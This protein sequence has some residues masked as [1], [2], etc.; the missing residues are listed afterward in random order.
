MANT[1]STNVSYVALPAR[2][3]LNTEGR[4]RRFRFRKNAKRYTDEQMKAVYKPRR[5]LG[6]VITDK[7]GLVFS[8]FAMA[9]A[10]N[11]SMMR[12]FQ[13][14]RYADMTKEHVHTFVQAMS[15]FAHENGWGDDILDIEF[16]NLKAYR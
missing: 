4:N 13:I 15:D 11:S 5:F 16:Q 8:N 10:V 9:E 2:G 7:R 14:V 3:F 6:F 12:H 1:S